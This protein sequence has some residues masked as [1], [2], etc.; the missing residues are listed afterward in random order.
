MRAAVVAEIAGAITIVLSTLDLKTVGLGLIIP[1][2]L[3]PSALSYVACRSRTDLVRW[4]TWAFFIPLLCVLLFFVA[5]WLLGGEGSGFG[6]TLQS[7]SL[8]PAVPRLSLC[9]DF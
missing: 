1:L 8:R 7:Y 4:S 5:G 9:A 3:I 6:S 2:F